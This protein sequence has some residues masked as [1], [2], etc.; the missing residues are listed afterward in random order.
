MSHGEEGVIF[1]T[2]GVPVQLDEIFSMFDNKNCLRLKGKPK[3]FFI[4]ACRG[5]K[6]DKDEPDG[7]EPAV[8]VNLKREIRNLLHLP[9]DESDGPL[10]DSQTTRTDMLCG[11]ATQPGYKSFR[12][13]ENGSW[14]IQD[15]TKVFMEHAKDK[16][17]RE[18]MQN[19]IEDVSK[20]T[21]FCPGTPDH[22]GK[23][24]AEFDHSLLKPLY[25][26]PGL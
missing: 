16:S 11:Y 14:F 23:E 2:D 8:K 20:R 18:M 1:G 6:V 19:V 13:R 10:Q 5:S 7:P 25:F 21:A 17:L 9:E 3:L 15:I 22:G 24:K 12:N 4:Q 26:F